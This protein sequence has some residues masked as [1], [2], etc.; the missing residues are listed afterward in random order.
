MSWTNE[1]EELQL[2]SIECAY[3]VWNSDLVQDLF[4]KMVALKL[5]GYRARHPYGVLP[6]DTYDFIAS[7]HLVC[8]REKGELFPVTGFKTTTLD[9][10]RMHK[11]PF[12]GLT[13]VEAAGAPEH[14]EVVRGIIERC[15]REGIKLGYTSSWTID[16]QAREDKEFVAHL[17]AIIEMIYVFFHR[18]KQLD[19]LIVGG[20]VRVGTDRLF[21]TWGHEPLKRNGVVLP[22]IS[23]A[24]LLGDPV[25][26]MYLR[27]FS[28]EVQARAEQLR[29]LWKN[30][31]V[32]GGDTTEI[33]HPQQLRGDTMVA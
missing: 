32:L 13:L 3:D 15:E 24:H 27:R 19:E 2:V 22:P 11:L 20:T 33:P 25:V 17:R 7:H 4:G 12:P 26:V 8:R 16:P 29:A 1:H 5:K 6:V 30:R 18:E 28:D 31:I 14:A 9:R 23:V 10:C 21:E